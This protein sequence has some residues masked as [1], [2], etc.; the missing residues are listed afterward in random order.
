MEGKE[1]ISIEYNCGLQSV[2]GVLHKWYHLVLL[3][4]IPGKEYSPHFAGKELEAVGV[5][6][7]QK[8][9]YYE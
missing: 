3:A 8:M 4:I 5:Q 7:S 6:V 2:P 1:P 9:S